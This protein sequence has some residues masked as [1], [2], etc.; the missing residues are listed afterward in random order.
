M[1]TATIVSAEKKLGGYAIRWAGVSVALLAVLCFSTPAALGQCSLSGT[2]S[3]WSDGNS[4]WNNSSNWSPTGVPNSSSR[5]T[6]I[7]DG[8]STVTLNINATV[9]NLQLASG[10]A[11]NVQQSSTLVVAGGLSNLGAINTGNDVGDAGNNAVNVSGSLINNGTITLAS[12]GGGDSLSAASLT[13]A[14]AINLN[15]GGELSAADLTNAGAINL[16]YSWLYDSG[17]FN[18]S[19]GGSLNMGAEAGM[20]VAG[21]FDNNSGASLFSASSGDIG[22]GGAFNNNGGT[23]WLSG[24]METL[25]TGTFNNNG[26][27]LIVQVEAGGVSVRGDFNNNGGGSVI[28]APDTNTLSVAG[29]FNNNSGASVVLYDIANNV[30]VGGAFNNNGG[31]VEVSG[32]SDSLYAGTFNNNGGTVTMSGSQFDHIL[33]S[34]AFNNNAGTVTLDVYQNSFSV[35]GAFNNNGGTVI[36]SGNGD[37][38]SANSFSNTG[39]SLLVGNGESMSVTHDYT[40]AGAGASTKVNGTLTATLTSIQGGTLSGSGTIVGDVN[41]SGGNVIPIDP[42]NPTTLTINGNYTQ[43]PNGTLT[44]DLS[45]TGSGDFSVLAVT[46]NAILGG[47]VDFTAIGG[48]TPVAGDDFTFL[49][50]GS[51]SGDFAN[52]DFTGWNCVQCTEVFGTNSLTLEVNRTPEPSIFLLL[53]MGIATMTI[54]LKYRNAVRVE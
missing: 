16:N 44:I 33:V 13:N 2:V 1:L 24:T 38:L 30:Y 22:V 23:V 17:D 9:D 51:E 3:T 11:L 37:T 48:F 28:M 36:L 47:T 5:S 18:N 4:N 43:G 46:G 31:A 15:N 39:G 6:C 19:S 12:W 26:G 49:T 29:D 14:G 27:S 21:H 35:G 34:G 40:Q 25:Y 53:V 10:N 50:F 32:D 8:S 42:G 41:N 20:S 52:M 54:L 45:G 7:T